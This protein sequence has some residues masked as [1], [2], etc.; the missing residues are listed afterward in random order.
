MALAVR[1]NMESNVQVAKE[2]GPDSFN[3]EKIKAKQA[4]KAILREKSLEAKSNIASTMDY[5]ELYTRTVIDSSREL[6]DLQCMSAPDN[7]RKQLKTL[8]KRD[9]EKVLNDLRVNDTKTKIPEQDPEGHLKN[10]P[11]RDILS[12]FRDQCKEPHTGGTGLFSS[13]HNMEPSFLSLCFPQVILINSP[14]PPPN[15]KANHPTHHSDSDSDLEDLYY[16]L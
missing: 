6:A 14:P 10:E 4:E 16:R 3:L 15:F 8:T 12:R 13:G 1:Q 2:E 7:V 11:G 5:A 9:C